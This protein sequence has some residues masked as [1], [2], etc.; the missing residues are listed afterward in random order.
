MRLTI[1]VE[2]DSSESALDLAR[3]WIENTQ[4]VVYYPDFPM[5]AEWHRLSKSG[6]ELR[7]F[8]EPTAIKGDSDE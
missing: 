2:S 1:I 3:D 6:T 4:N 7:A 5:K 8:I